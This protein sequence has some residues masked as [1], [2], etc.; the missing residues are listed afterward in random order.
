MRLFYMLLNW[1]LCK[2]LNPPWFVSVTIIILILLSF[3]VINDVTATN[4]SCSCRK[5]EAFTIGNTW[6]WNKYPPPQ[7]LLFHKFLFLVYIFTFSSINVHDTYNMNS[8]YRIS[9]ILIEHSLVFTRLLFYKL[10]KGT[11][12]KNT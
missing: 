12:F 9:L 5:H 8:R 6:H 4:E 11:K 10:V 1:K 7:N 2:F 3:K